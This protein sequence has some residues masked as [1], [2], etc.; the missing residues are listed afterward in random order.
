MVVRRN[1]GA[2]MRV[3]CRRLMKCNQSAG[4]VARAAACAAYGDSEVFRLFHTDETDLPL[5]QGLTTLESFYKHFAA[6]VSGMTTS[7]DESL[8]ELEARHYRLESLN[9][10]LA[11]IEKKISKEVQLDRKYALAK[12]KQRIV[13]EIKQCQNSKK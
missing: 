7:A 4:S 8:R 13:K 9:A 2:I 10:D 3:K 11:D 6:A 1:D 12:E 5:P